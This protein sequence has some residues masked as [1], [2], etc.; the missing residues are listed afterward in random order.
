MRPA[1][2]AHAALLALAL[3]G[4]TAEAATIVILNGDGA[5]EGLNDPN[6]PAHANQIGNNPGTTL[7]QLR[8][9]LLEAAA[10]RW[11][12]LLNSAV[13]INVNVQFNPLTCSQ[14]GG[15]L[16]QAGPSASA[17][18]FAGGDPNV[19]YHI[20]LAESLAGTNLNGGSVEL[21]AVFN[22]TVDTNNVN[23]LGGGGFYYGLDDNAPAGTAR[24]FATAL[25]E[26]A[27]GLSFS[28]LVDFATGA[29][30]GSGGFPDAYSRNLFDWGTGK[31][32]DQMNN[33]ERLASATNDPSLVWNGAT[34]TANRAAFLDPAPEV[35]INAPAGIVGT[36]LANLGEEPTIVMPQGGVTAAV[37]DGDAILTGGATTSCVGAGAFAAMAGRIVLFEEPAG[38][39]AAI[40]AFI[41]QLNGAV[42]ALLSNPNAPGLPDMSGQIDNQAVTI[43]YVGVSQAVGNALRANIATA[44]ATIRNH[45]TVRNGDNKGLL[46][47]HA[48]AGFTQGSSVA[49]WTGAARPDLLMESTLGSVSFNQVDLTPSAFADMGW[50][51]NLGELIF[52]DGFEDP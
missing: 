44:N 39:I 48:P 29:F 47:M 25:H 50:S 26:F 5:G 34:V 6:P 28:P 49:H 35:A 21:S 30:S 20:A 15:V 51:V 9:N 33:A 8:M 41:A 38:C 46:R 31:S 3:I 19:A 7:G 52:E 40:P 22:S 18:N 27:H 32:W 1:G 2:T 12:Q 43:P 24:L 4:G 16:G 10:N 14:F 11:E 42:G 37:V 45:A 13:T 23:C 17:A 36:H